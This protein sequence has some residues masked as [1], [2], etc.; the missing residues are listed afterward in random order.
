MHDDFPLSELETDANVITE[1]VKTQTARTETFL[2]DEVFQRDK[3]RAQAILEDDSYIDSVRQRGRWHY[4]FLQNNA[5]PKGLWRRL[6]V[7]DAIRVD[8]D[9]QPVF[10]LDRF[11][12]ETGEDWHWRG[13][14]CAFFDPEKILLALSWQGSDQTRYL[15][16][17]S[18]A[19][20][21]VP[22]GFDLGPERCAA[23]WVDTDTLLFT[24]SSSEGAATRSGW[25]R[26]VL[27]LTR[28]M[29]VSEAPVVFE[30][31]FEDVMALA[32][33]YPS[34][35]G[36]VAEATLRVRQIGDTA[37]V[38]Y[39][40]GLGGKAIALDTP[41][42]TEAAFTT[43]H[44]A[45][46][47]GQ[48]G[49]DAPGT[50]VLREIGGELHRVLFEPRRYVS[51]DSNSC[52]MGHDWMLWIEKDRMQPSLRAL[53]LRD[54]EADPVTLPLPC[55]AQAIGVFEHV[56]SGVW[57]GPLQLVTTGFL[58]P[59]V[60][61]RFDMKNG[62]DGVQF[63]KLTEQNSSFD[64]T[65]MEVR[66]ESAISDDG[67]EVPYH[68]VLPA[69]RQGPVPVMQ[70]GYGG[71]G[72]ALGPYY[73]GVA[74]ALWLERGGAMVIGYIRGGGEFGSDWHHAAKRHK[75]MKSYED[76]AA[77][78]AD[79]VA[80]GF[81]KSDLIGA[82]GGSNGGLLA[83]VMLTR[84][85]DRFGAIAAQ[86]AVTDMLRF[87]LFPAGAAWMDEYGDPDD[88]DDRAV[89]LGYSPMHNIAPVATQTY[90][91]ALIATNSTD[92]RV[93][94]SHSRRFAA[95]LQAAGQDAWFH[96]QSGGHGGGG[97]TARDAES[98]ALLYAFFR[99]TLMT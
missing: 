75:R 53:D 34:R 12:A 90:P 82:H 81:S 15:E 74:G 45:Y 49:P 77:I 83:S 31:E 25:A 65:G 35:D 2:N 69:D 85:P 56:A 87:H 32:F 27:R 48:Y 9:W 92:D 98:R 86:V 24:T 50:L 30:G 51:V 18:A 38:L 29:T 26:R 3:A 55:E 73:P 64:A 93:D 41:R 36:S 52:V 44:Y 43:T 14:E 72:V 21:P 4:N 7:E 62:T 63:E 46:V 68:I 96:S 28:G 8:A 58:Q 17:D 66:L 23:S 91:T 37:Y 84:Y 59:T 6:P 13:A 70:Y 42:D 79:L 76:F 94:P 95:A 22:D 16:W 80:K 78:A 67:T 89:M 19:V 40:D 97:S 88:P 54:P 1:F 10:D 47:A 5:H 33:G 61:W 71:Y 60:T 99:N 20:Q 57:D 39:P 11:C